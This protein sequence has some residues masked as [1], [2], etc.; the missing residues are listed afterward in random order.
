MADERTG[1]SFACKY[2]ND[3]VTRWAPFTRDE[4]MAFRAKMISEGRIKEMRDELVLRNAGLIPRFGRSW[5]WLYGREDAVSIGITGLYEAAETFDFGREDVRFSTYAGWYL[6]RAF[7]GNKDNYRNR[8]DEASLPFDQ[9]VAY[10]DDDSKDSVPLG[11]VLLKFADPTYAPANAPD[12]GEAIPFDAEKWVNEACASYRRNGTG[13]M[14]R[15]SLESVRRYL[16]VKLRHPDYSVEQVFSAAGIKHVSGDDPS[17]TTATNLH[18]RA[19]KLALAYV[20]KQAEATIEKPDINAY[21]RKYKN[22]ELNKDRLRCTR[23]V[24]RGGGWEV[25]SYDPDARGMPGDRGIA[26]QEWKLA[27][28]EWERQILEKA[29]QFMFEAFGKDINCFRFQARDPLGKLSYL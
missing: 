24:W 9:P 20:R 10:S 14:N 25:E 29:E 23:L 6:R 18:S 4:E 11:D 15:R 1:P 27:M 16:I 22:T 8:V 28:A 19:V 12:P 5:L 2:F 26:T 13:G 21:Y 3:I 17:R 7:N